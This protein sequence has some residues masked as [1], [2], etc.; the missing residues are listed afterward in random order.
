MTDIIRLL[1]DSVAN[2]IAAGEVIQRPASALKEML[3]NSID[4]GSSY[5]KII[6]KDAGRTLIQV[7][8]NGCGMS[9]T[10]ARMCFERHA[11]SKI[12]SVNDLFAIRTMGFRGEALA[13]IASIAHVELKTRKHEDE[14]GTE[15][16]IEGAEVKSHKPCSCTVG[17]SISVKNLFFN[18]PARRNFLKSNTVETRHIIEEFTRISLI[19]P[20]IEFLLFH[21]NK[22]IFILKKSIL[23]QRI[24]GLFGNNFN[25]RIVPIEQK[26]SFVK[27]SGFIG[28]PE[29]A[30]RTRGQQYFFVNG[31]FIR[32]P[33][34][35]HAV[36][37]A[38]QELIPEKSYPAYFINI[39]VDTK[40]I[41]INIHPTKTEI[42]FMDEKPI[43]AILRSTI[44]QSL[45]KFNLTPTID[46]DV[47]QSFIYTP[48]PKDHPVSPPVIKVNPD[49]NPFD[50]PGIKQFQRS[51]SPRE[52]SN[53]ENWEKLFE[54]N[55]NVQFEQT[56]QQSIEPEWMQQEKAEYRPLQ[57][58][59]LQ[60][61]YILSS[62]KSGLIIIDQQNAHER[63]LYEQFLGQLESKK[64]NS[65]QQLHPQ[66]FTLSA[67]DAEILKEIIDEIH[68]LG[69]DISYR[70]K[71]SFLIKG[72][73]A[74]ISKENPKGTIEGMIENFK[75]NLIDIRVEKSINLARSMAKRIAVKHG[76]N[77]QI[78]EMQ[79]L[80]DRL[81]ACKQPYHSLDGK[82]TLITI[83]F[84]EIENRFI[85][86]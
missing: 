10:D 77:L 36:D 12:R 14:L 22:Q 86:K 83:N 56:K 53:K 42:K 54:S 4:S 71:N 64:G 55:D 19:N 85:V 18:V 8:D 31:R 40:T 78:E 30:K 33:Y 20:D 50:I 28:K 76:E 24:V 17:T 74:S 66:T 25:Q 48:P 59:Q 57:A 52:K 7:I 75:R 35:H 60:K 65:Q 34:L 2:Q 16:C 3:E 13:S 44:K 51:E 70:G 38:Y 39:E 67:A 80:I 58:S 29:F 84:E 5:I 41:D 72:I 79:D 15:I 9:E 26:T 32:H 43:Y 21:N 49:Y 6:I 46:F 61:R 73:P 47:E 63:I 62:I 45:G 11:T 68:W 82:P 69:F 27:I 1:P 37:N 23:K 81:F